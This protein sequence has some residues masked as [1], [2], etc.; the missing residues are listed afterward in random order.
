MQ[1]ALRIPT[2]FV[3]DAFAFDGALAQQVV[4]VDGKFAGHAV[5]VV[6]LRFA[7]VLF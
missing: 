6:R 7:R 1:H 4:D 2:S 5:A 3:L